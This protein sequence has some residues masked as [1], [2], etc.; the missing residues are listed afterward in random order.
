MDEMTIARLEQRVKSLE[1]KQKSIGQSGLI[2]PKFWTRIFT[3][4]G[5]QLVISAVFFAAYMLFALILGIGLAA[6]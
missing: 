3:L 1:E 6:R 5:Y 4:V 2:S